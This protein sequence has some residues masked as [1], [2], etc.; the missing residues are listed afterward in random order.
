MQ[1]VC[2][3][4]LFVL[5]LLFSSSAVWGQTQFELP[6]NLELKAKEDYNRH[7]T[8]LVEAA[9]WLEQTALS[10]EVAKRQEINA[11]VI[12]YLSG[13]PT[14]SVALNEQLAK[15]Y[16]KNEQLLAI[17]LASYGRN[18]IENRNSTDRSAPVKGGLTSM[19]NV[20]KKGVQIEKSREMEKL[21]KL[22]D[23]ELNTYI[24]QKLI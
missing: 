22:S 19:M 5:S 11:F 7:E 21:L 24:S 13:S 17:Y 10:S 20:Y 15:I 9:K 14:I 4:V 12:K 6:K 8:T 23:S 16:G 2:V 3:V 18:V 1:R